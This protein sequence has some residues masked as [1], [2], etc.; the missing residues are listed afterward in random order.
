[1]IVVTGGAGFIGSNLV[2]GLNARGYDDILVVDHLT[3]GIKYKNLVDG[4]I[5]DYLDRE[6]FLQ[7]LQQGDFSARS[8][9]AIFHQGACSTTTEWDGRYMM[10]NNYEYS[11]ALLH[12]C[13]DHKIPFIYASS[14]AVYGADLTFKEELAY[15]GPLNVY[16]Y[17][18]FQ[19]D[20]YLRR[21]SR[22]TA[23]VVG[24]RYFNVY[25]PREAHKGS[26][27]SVAFHLNEQIKQSDDIRLFEG[28][29]GYGHG[30]QRRDFVYVGDVVDVNLWF[31]D[32]PQ[33]SGIF[34]CGTGRSQTFNDVANAVIRFHRR[35]RIHYIPFPDHLKGCYQSY[36]EANLDKL[37]AAGCQHEFKTVEQGVQAYMA[38]LNG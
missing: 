25:G 21:Q 23:Q 6:T 10:S 30:E 18:K 27:A 2:L 32:N 33:V 3:N 1:M 35:G 11:K 7:R 12:Y 26:M 24:L 19:F 16:G 17:S 38:W 9:A 20:Q 31:L 22:L 5:A 8:I 28:C 15:E 36:T 29:D 37:R 13:Q 34:N 4:R 14:A